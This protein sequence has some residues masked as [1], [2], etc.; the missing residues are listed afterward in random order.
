MEILVFAGASTA[1]TYVSA[2]YLGG[3]GLG[4]AINCPTVAKG[5]KIGETFGKLGTV[6]ENGGQKII[7][8]G[9]HGAKRMAERGLTKTVMQTT[10]NNPLVQLVQDGGRKH[11]YLT[12]KAGVVLDKV[13]KVIT[14]YSQKYFDREVQS[15]ISKA[16]G[17]K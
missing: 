7:D 2:Q 11:L 8:Y 4:C 15:I 10:T 17:N 6:V 16:L 3:I 1:A 12:E 9:F 14:T 5:L 13:G